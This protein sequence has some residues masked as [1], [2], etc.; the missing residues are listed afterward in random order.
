LED[1]RGDK[2]DFVF[3]FPQGEPTKGETRLRE[4]VKN[5]G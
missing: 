2:K 3:L 5:A 4:K 1:H